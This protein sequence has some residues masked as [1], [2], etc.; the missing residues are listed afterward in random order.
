MEGR[1]FIMV[2]YF[3]DY[4]GKEVDKL[5]CGRYNDMICKDCANKEHEMV[6]EFLSDHEEWF[7]KRKKELVKQYFG[8]YAA[9]SILR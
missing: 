5:G 6:M 9:K 7:K 4:C 2:K 8:T 3:C 1:Y